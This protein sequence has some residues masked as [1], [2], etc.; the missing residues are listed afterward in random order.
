MLVKIELCP[1]CAG[2]L[3]KIHDE[4]GEEAVGRACGPTVQA[5]EVCRVQLPAGEGT[6]VTKWRATER[7]PMR[8]R[9]PRN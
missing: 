4:E 8:S 7:R 5:C 3:R 1:S 2:K 6:L 9:G